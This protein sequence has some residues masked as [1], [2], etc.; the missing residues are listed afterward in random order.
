M[1]VCPAGHDSLAADY[2]DTCGTRIIGAAHPPTL[3]AVPTSPPPPNGAAAVPASPPL[4]NA[5]A[6]PPSGA[7]RTDVTGPQGVPSGSDMCP[8]CGVPRADGD[9][10]CE[11]CGFDFV[12]AASR[13]EQPPKVPPTPPPATTAAAN[14]AGP[15]P[16]APTG[17][18]V[19]LPSVRAALAAAA[20][21]EAASGQEKNPDKP[22]QTWTAEVSA[23]REYFR[24]AAAG[25]DLDFPEGVPPRV[26]PLTAE[27]VRIGRRSASRGL[28]PEIDLSGRPADPGISHLHAVLVAGV[29]GW[30][31]IDPGSTNGTTLNDDETPLAI[32]MPV[33]VGDGD[34]IHLGAWT[35]ITLRKHSA[36]NG[37]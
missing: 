10:F 23:D 34:R 8:D 33:P 31:L 6:Q 24:K 7:Q 28:D 27:Q 3:G 9:R 5:A 20:A 22:G 25:D 19:T 11:D 29:G 12:V 4:S 37:R 35:T 36:E 32:N 14:G 18:D 1:P 16:T 21:A 13:S 26:V 30:Q 2:C 17:R 15:T